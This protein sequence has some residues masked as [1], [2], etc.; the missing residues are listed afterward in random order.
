MKN[1]RNIS[2]IPLLLLASLVGAAPPSR[3][4]PTRWEILGG[5]TDWRWEESFDDRRALLES[6][7]VPTLR[8][9][10]HRDVGSWRV[11]ADLETIYGDIAYEGALQDQEGRLRSYDSRTHYFAGSGEGGAAYP[12][13]PAAKVTLVPSLHLGY[14]RWIRTIDS[15]RF[16]EPGIHGYLETWQHVAVQP[17]LG[18]EFALR[19]H[20]R[21]LVEA[22]VRL[23]IWTLET[24]AGLAGTSGPFDLEPG[25]ESA[26]RAMLQ[27]RLGRI[28]IETE[29]LSLPF[30]ASPIVSI[31]MRI[32]TPDGTIQTVQRDLHQPDS[33]L[34]RLDLRAGAWF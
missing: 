27:V 2:L 34:R 22:G 33:D 19:G 21:I 6:G 5:A 11:M 15:D 30:Q 26:F 23:P 1:P 32:R 16:N 12:L 17:R 10:V 24:I 31:P 28:L 3:P 14:H 4:A 18:A 29:W 25:T 20:D 8:G 9:R 13:R 7:F